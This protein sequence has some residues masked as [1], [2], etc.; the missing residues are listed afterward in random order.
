MNND[1]MIKM[2]ATEA[3]F[4]ALGAYCGYALARVSSSVSITG[5]AMLWGLTP[6]LTVGYCALAAHN[7]RTLNN[8]TMAACAGLGYLTSF[9][10][11]NLSGH[12]VTIIAPFIGLTAAG[13]H[14]AIVLACVGTIASIAFVVFKMVK[15]S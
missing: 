2:A 3:S 10:I 9:A 11:T 12:S 1:M 13:I 14:G 5:H 8:A 15:S 7:N 4:I 6:A